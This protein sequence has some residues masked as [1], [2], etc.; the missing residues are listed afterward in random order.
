MAGTDDFERTKNVSLHDNF[1]IC[2]IIEISFLMNT[3]SPFAVTACLEIFLIL[4]LE[5]FDSLG[6]RS[7]E[8]KLAEDPE[9]KRQEIF[10]SLTEIVM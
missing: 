1:L 4:T 3:A 9:S 2:I 7:L 6:I 10:I 5:N 8:I